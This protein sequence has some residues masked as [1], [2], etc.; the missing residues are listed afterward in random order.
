MSQLKFFLLCIAVLVV[1]VA[2]PFLFNYNDK[3]ALSIACLGSFG[4]IATLYVAYV[5]FITYNAPADIQKKRFELVD[6]ALAFFITKRFL[7]ITDREHTF[8]SYNTKQ[9]LDNCLQVLNEDNCQTQPVILSLE[10][11]EYLMDF[12]NQLEHHY[13]PYELKMLILS[14][15]PQGLEF[16]AENE[17]RGKIKITFSYD[18]EKYG[19]PIMTNGVTDIQG[20]INSINTIRVAMIKYLNQNV[21]SE[22]QIIDEKI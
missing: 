20:Y 2:T 14:N 17:F 4:T 3:L 11:L 9:R 5:I 12:Q 6:S 10:I 8:F 16:L 22:Y 1:S 21:P 19:Y 13:F 18:T 15:L 7:I